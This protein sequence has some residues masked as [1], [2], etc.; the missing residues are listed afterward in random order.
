VGPTHFEKPGTTE[1][2]EWQ[3]GISEFEY[4]LSEQLIALHLTTHLHST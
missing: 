4:S 3:M 2:Q 1:D